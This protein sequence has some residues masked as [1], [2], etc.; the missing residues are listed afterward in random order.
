MRRD[1]L[2]RLVDV[3]Q[4]GVPIAA[5]HRRAHGE[6]DQ[7]GRTRNGCKLGCEMQPA[8]AHVFLDERVEPRLVNR[9]L[10]GFQLLD[11]AGIL[12]DASNIPAEIGET[13]G[14]NQADISGPNHANIHGKRPRCG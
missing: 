11:L 1:F 3:G 8:G 13:G 6:E 12:L 7:V 5:P 14:G 10:A 2:D 9:D 4:V